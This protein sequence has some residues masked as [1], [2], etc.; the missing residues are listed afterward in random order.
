MQLYT[1]HMQKMQAKFGGVNG[2]LGPQNK[3]KE[4]KDIEHEEVESEGESNAEPDLPFQST[5]GDLN[6]FNQFFGDD[7]MNRK[8]KIDMIEDGYHPDL[9]FLNPETGPNERREAI[10]RCCGMNLGANKFKTSSL[11]SSDAEFAAG[12]PNIKIKM[13]SCLWVNKSNSEAFPLVWRRATRWERPQR[14]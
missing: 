9:V 1:T 7:V 2:L 10:R 14:G 6:Q 12:D 11:D 5:D 3:R 4:V 8:L 13:K